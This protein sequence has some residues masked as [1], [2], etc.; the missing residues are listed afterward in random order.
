M[1]CARY[2]VIDS[3]VSRYLLEIQFVVLHGFVFYQFEK[4]IG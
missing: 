1:L 2:A 4:E 3:L